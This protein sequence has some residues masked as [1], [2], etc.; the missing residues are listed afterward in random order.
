[1]TVVATGRRTGYDDG[2]ST[3]TP[4]TGL[5]GDAPSATTDVSISGPNNKVGTTLTLTAPTWST[6]G[7][8]TTYQWFRDSTA[9]TG[10]TGTTYRLTDA[11]VGLSVTVR[12]TGAKTGYLPGTS[13]S[14][15]IVGAALDPVVNTGAPTISGVAA[16]RE[17]LRA[18]TGTWAVT[19]G[20]SYTY[21]WFIDGVAVAKETKSTY[22]VRTID[23]GRSVSV[24]V[25]AT[26]TGWAAGSSTSAAMPV[27]KLAST[28][29]ASLA[30]KKITQKKRGVLTVKVAMIGYDVPLGQVRIK[31]GSKVIGTVALTK[32]S[33]GTVTI[34]L[35]KLKKGKHK[36][37]VSY[38]GSESTLGSAAKPL[39]L[40]VVRGA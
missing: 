25:A 31:D 3:S 22:V 39:V 40:R 32:A 24:R 37:V 30:S 2:A 38:L 26:A 15:G 20:V 11:D 21:Q 5:I 33:N 4:V 14:N 28:T 27:S 23:A 7:V 36:L 16:A 35:K 29:T 1:M 13:T 6:T 18:S 19:S 10:S 34:R 9:I 17:T 12:A 8:A